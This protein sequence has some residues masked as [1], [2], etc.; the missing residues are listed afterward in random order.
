MTKQENKLCK[1]ITITMSP[2]SLTQSPRQKGGDGPQ[3]SEKLNGNDHK[4]KVG[5][6]LQLPPLESARTAYVCDCL[7]LVWLRL[8]RDFS[9]P[10]YTTAGVG[11]VVIYLAIL[12]NTIRDGGSTA[13]SH[14]LDLPC[15]FY[16][17]SHLCRSIVGPVSIFISVIF[18]V[19]G[20]I[21]LY[22]Y[23][24]CRG[25]IEPVYPG[26]MCQRQYVSVHNVVSRSITP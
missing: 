22:L 14:L 18:F 19:L 16:R 21:S 25:V 5:R 11:R 12:K 9:C 20:C 2:N 6:I 4:H 15:S 24:L 26:S 7:F 1:Y 10:Q 3:E 8:F 23:L 17:L 13:Q